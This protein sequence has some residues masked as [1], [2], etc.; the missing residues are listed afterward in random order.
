[1]LVSPAHYDEVAG[2]KDSDEKREIL[3]VLSEYGKPVEL[4]SVDFRKR[5]SILQSFNIRIVD[6]AHLAF[7]ETGAQ[8]FITCDD[9]LIKQYDR[10]SAGIQIGTPSVFVQQEAL[11]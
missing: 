6:A 1:M 3:K 8:W 4:K 2:I 7:A 5:V 9:R 11:K 10:S